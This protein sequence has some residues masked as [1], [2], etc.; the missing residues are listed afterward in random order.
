MRYLLVLLFIIAVPVSVFSAGVDIVEV[1]PSALFL[2]LEPGESRTNYLS[3]RNE[4]AKDTAVTFQAT[5]IEITDSY[6]HVKKTQ[7]HQWSLAEWVSFES[8]KYTVPAQS[9]VKIPFTVTVPEAAVLGS[10]SGA[11]TII[12][13]NPAVSLEKGTVL[14]ANVGAVTATVLEVD[15]FAPAGTQ[16]VF[17]LQNKGIHLTQ[18]Y[19][20]V[21]WYS[22]RDKEINTEKIEA[23]VVPPG[24]GV[25]LYF[26]F[27]DKWPG[28]YKA[29][30]DVLYAN[31][32]KRIRKQLN[33]IHVP[34]VFPVAAGIVVVGGLLVFAKFKK[35]HAKKSK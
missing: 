1:R 22:L 6:G 20:T 10:Y 30:V 9:A 18:V 24:K 7:A 16:L 5:S 23:V 29:D 15:E 34:P 19:G 35:K 11:I 14:Y 8:Q 17:S 31:G 26:P 27:A 2:R 33:V 28:I 32:N 21:T 13:E 4:T 12:S 25:T 3:L